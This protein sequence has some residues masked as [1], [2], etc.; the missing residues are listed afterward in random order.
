VK[1]GYWGAVRALTATG[2]VVGSVLGA[3]AQQPTPEQISAIRAS[4]RSD[5]MAHCTG[6]TPGTREAL[7]CLKHNAAKVSPSCRTALDAVGPPPGESTAPARTKPT[8]A[9]AAEAPPAAHEA[10][11]PAPPPPAE[12]GQ[13]P[14]PEGEPGPPPGPPSEGHEHHHSPQ[15]AAIRAAC[16]SDFGVHCPGV[17]PG[18]S[19]ALRCLQANAAALSPPCREAVMAMGEGGAPPEGAGAAPPPPVAPIGPI[20]PMWPRTA[21]KILSFCRAERDTLCGNVPPGG[22]RVLECLA[23]N[24]ARLSPECYGALARAAAR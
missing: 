6:V 15:A 9:P 18:G 20:P 24:Y 22:G 2:I 13:S 23:E 12:A 21:L 19:A 10:P 3:A 8:P 5:F 7:E 1:L 16:R 17:R 4:C 11:A 14:A